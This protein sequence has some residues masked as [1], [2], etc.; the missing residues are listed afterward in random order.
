MLKADSAPSLARDPPR[1]WPPRARAELLD[2][3]AA[4]SSLTTEV[5]EGEESNESSTVP[6]D[7]DSTSVAVGSGAL[8]DLTDFKTRITNFQRDPWV[9]AST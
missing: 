5:V 8:V 4:S 6:M 9:D 2:A 3:P 1:H 7:V